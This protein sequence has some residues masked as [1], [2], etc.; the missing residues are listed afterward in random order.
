LDIIDTSADIGKFGVNRIGRRTKVEENSKINEV[1]EADIP[2]I[3]YIPNDGNL[4]QMQENIAYYIS[5]GQT[6][7]FINSD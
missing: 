3:V 7:A 5:I 2:D 6:Y 4:T 1:F